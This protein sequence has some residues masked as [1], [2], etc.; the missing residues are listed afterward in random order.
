MQNYGEPTKTVRLV[1]EGAVGFRIHYGNEACQKQEHC[2][3]DS[4]SW[5]LLSLVEPMKTRTNTR[6]VLKKKQCCI[7]GFFKG[8]LNNCQHHIPVFLIWLYS[9]IYL[10]H[11]L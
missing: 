3:L 7:V 2:S 1:V 6:K 9:A 8:G 10:R 5:V 4:Y 11:T